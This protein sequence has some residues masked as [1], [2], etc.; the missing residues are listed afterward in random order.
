MRLVLNF[1]G[2][3]LE[4]PEPVPAGVYDARVDASQAEVKKSQNGNDYVTLT[5][6]I[7]NHPEYAGRKV[8]ENY[9]LTKKSLWKLGRA[10]KALGVISGTNIAKVILDFSKDVHGKRCRIKVSQE[11]YNGRTRNRVDEVMSAENTVPQ[12]KIAF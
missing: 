7:E 2:V 8:F 12:R 4:G 5:Y 1:D 11:E 3:E 6:V 9:T 10:L